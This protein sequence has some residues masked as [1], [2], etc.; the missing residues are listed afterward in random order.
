MLGW[1]VATVEAGPPEGFSAKLH[2]ALQFV[3]TAFGAASPGGLDHVEADLA[4][5][6]LLSDP[7]PAEA[8]QRLRAYVADLTRPWMMV[9]SSLQPQPIDGLLLGG[10]ASIHRGSRC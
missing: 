5:G 10:S 7:F 9:A 4:S 6:R 2:E 8:T 3:L 1:S